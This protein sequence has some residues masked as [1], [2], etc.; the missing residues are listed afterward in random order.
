MSDPLL[1]SAEVAAILR[2]SRTTVGRLAADGRL[3]YARVGKRQRYSRADVDAY[4]ERSRVGV[5]AP[6]IPDLMRRRP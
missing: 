5:S 1:T 2:V 6:A 4:L 3:S